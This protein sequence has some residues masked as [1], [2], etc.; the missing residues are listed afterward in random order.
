[1]LVCLCVCF[2][3]IYNNN[4]LSSHCYH[5]ILQFELSFSCDGGL[6]AGIKRGKGNFASPLRALILQSI[7]LVYVYVFQ[8]EIQPK[9]NHQMS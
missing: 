9:T 7:K 6:L 1:M 5:L 3:P 2:K 8:N 4:C